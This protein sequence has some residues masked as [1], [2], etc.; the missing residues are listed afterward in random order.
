[1][2]VSVRLFNK[3]LHCSCDITLEKRIEYLTLAINCAKSYQGPRVIQ[4]MDMV[5]RL[6]QDLE[7]AN[8]QLLHHFSESKPLVSM[9]F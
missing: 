5:R 7:T 4:M 6:E 2:S 9:E 3:L 8:A 1:M